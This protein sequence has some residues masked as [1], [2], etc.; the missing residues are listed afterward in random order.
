MLPCTTKSVRQEPA[1]IGH[2][3]VHSAV[4][5][6]VTFAWRMRRGDD[7]DGRLK[8]SDE[9]SLYRTGKRN[10]GVR[11]CVGTPTLRSITQ[12]PPTAIAFKILLDNDLQFSARRSEG[13]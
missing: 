5:C 9:A 6:A 1:L 4:G 3:N 13:C 8:S 12:V 7:R 2:G 11:A 10:T